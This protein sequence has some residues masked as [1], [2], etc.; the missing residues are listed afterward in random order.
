MGCYLNLFFVFKFVLFVKVE[1]NKIDNKG[2]FGVRNVFF[3]FLVYF[4]YKFFI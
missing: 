1:E 3:L 4:L 2:F